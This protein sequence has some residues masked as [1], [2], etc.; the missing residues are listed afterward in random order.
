MQHLGR[1]GTGRDRVRGDSFG[2]QLRR[3]ALD[4][5][6]HGMLRR[7]VTRQERKPERAPGGRDSDEPPV[8]RPRPFEHGGNG[9]DRQPADT[10]EV[11]AEHHVP[12]LVVRVPRDCHQTQS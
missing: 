4:E 3:Q 8:P 6:D 5:A 9:S 2:T 1:R 11:D 10:L 12:H 7:G